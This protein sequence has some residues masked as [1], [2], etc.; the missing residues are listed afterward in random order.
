L[1]RSKRALAL[2]RDDQVSMVVVGFNLKWHQL[3]V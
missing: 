2:G 1:Q 3:T